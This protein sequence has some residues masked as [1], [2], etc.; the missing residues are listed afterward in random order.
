MP[1]LGPQGKSCPKCEQA[2]PCSL[3]AL[4]QTIRKLASSRKIEQPKL[5]T[6]YRIGSNDNGS[7]GNGSNDNTASRD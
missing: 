4:F 3:Y 2:F 6:M 5:R 1:A 7:N